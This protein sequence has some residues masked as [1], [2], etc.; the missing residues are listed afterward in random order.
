MG[1]RDRQQKDKRGR[2][3]DNSQYSRRN[4]NNQHY[5]RDKDHHYN[6]SPSRRDRD[7]RNDKN[8]SHHHI[9]QLLFNKSIISH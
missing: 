1:G 2:H 6:R 9:V 5:N 3:N 4:D 8:D 7:Y